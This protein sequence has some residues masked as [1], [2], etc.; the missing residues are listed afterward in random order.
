[1]TDS[2]YNC[3]TCGSELDYKTTKH[4]GC[5]NCGSVPLHSAD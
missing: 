2:C 5:P 3:V 4:N 1:M